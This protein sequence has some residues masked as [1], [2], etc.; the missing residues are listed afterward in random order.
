M[1]ERKKEKKK[2]KR[3]MTIYSLSIHS[4]ISIIAFIL[5]ISLVSSSLSFLQYFQMNPSSPELL[6]TP[7]KSTDGGTDNRSYTQSLSDIPISR[8][9]EHGNLDVNI[10]ARATSATSVPIIFQVPT[11]VTSFT[12]STDLQSSIYSSDYNRHSHRRSTNTTT[13][14]RQLSL[15]DPMSNRVSTILVWQNLTVQ[16]REDKGKKVFQH[17]KSYKTF[18][19]KRKCL[20]NNISGAITGGLWAVMGKFN[21]FK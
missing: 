2:K 5:L 10:S 21:S 8:S 19:P 12:K 1:K 18:V 15:L 11:N 13:L 16:I 20:L 4:Y 17:M 3:E 7:S 14:E 6:K 9:N